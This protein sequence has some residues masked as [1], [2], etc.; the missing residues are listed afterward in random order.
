MHV[1]WR[2]VRY[3]QGWQARRS[4]LRFTNPE[5]ASL[6]ITSLPQ[7]LRMFLVNDHVSAQPDFLVDDDFF[8]VDQATV[9][10]L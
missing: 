9:T 8:S 3:R 1:A 2:L 5:R 6:G 4:M 7:T 10:A